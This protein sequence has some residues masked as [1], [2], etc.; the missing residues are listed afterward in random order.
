MFDLSCGY[1]RSKIKYIVYRKTIKAT[2][3]YYGKDIRN[4]LCKNKSGFGR[5]GQAPDGYHEVR[6]V[7]QSIGLSDAVELEESEVLVVE[8]DNGGLA[9]RAR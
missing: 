5:A 6:M 8:T 1:A 2:R 9:R 4:S 7:M 3:L